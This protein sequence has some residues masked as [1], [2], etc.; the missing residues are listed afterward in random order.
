MAETKP[1]ADSRLIGRLVVLILLLAAVVP[2][3]WLATQLQWLNHQRHIADELE[4]HGFPVLVAAADQNTWFGELL[5]LTGKGDLGPI[6][7]IGPPGSNIEDADLAKIAGLDRLV[8]L[9][10]Q[11]TGVT[12]AGLGHLHDLPKLFFLNLGETKITDAGLAKLA[13]LP[14]LEAI[15][16]SH[17]KITGAGLEHFNSVGHLA[18]LD[19]GNTEVNDAGMVHISNTAQLQS[20]PPG[21]H[22]RPRRR[23]GQSRRSHKPYEPRPERDRRE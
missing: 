17:T 20:A 7:E 11:M 12:D 21:E 9:Q 3:A 6:V 22:G 16:L 18:E 2:L 8:Y 10:L 5:A 15:S 4:S 1:L 14:S 13:S 23:P 19:A